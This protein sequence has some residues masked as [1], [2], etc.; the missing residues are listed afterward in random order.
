MTARDLQRQLRERLGA[1]TV[2]SDD[3]FVSPPMPLF[4]CRCV[5]L[6]TSLEKEADQ[7]MRGSE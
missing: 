6:E 4:R 7:E 5:L 2:V 1:I 3:R